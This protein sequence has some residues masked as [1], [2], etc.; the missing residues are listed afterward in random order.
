[1]NES[2]TSAGSSPGATA[3]AD[4]IA[5]EEESLLNCVHCG[6]CLTACPTYARLGDE[7][8]SPRG[9]LYL[10]KAVVEGRMDA[11]SDAF[12]THIDRC[13]GCRAC[14][15][16]CPSGVP[17][18]HLLEYA[19]AEAVAA[20]R[21]GPL[22]RLL[23]G[24]FGSRWTTN[25][26][27][28]GGRIM[29]ATGL[30]KLAARMLPDALGKARFGLAMLASTAPGG[31]EPPPSRGPSDDRL[32]TTQPSGAT[33][34]RAG[35]LLG[36]V[37]AG[38]FAHV[39]AGTERVLRVNGVESVPVPGQGCCGALHAH[40]GDLGSARSLARR[41]I[42][43]F[44]DTGVDM[45][46]VN[47]A[48]CGS[49][50][51][52]YGHLLADD[53]EYAERAARFSRTVRDV[54]EVLADIGPRRGAPL[55]L[56][57]AWDAPCHLLHAQRVVDPPR[58][59]LAAIPELDLVEVENSEECCGGAGVYGLVHEELGGWIGG[60]K[61]AAVI[62]TKAP[63]LATGNPGCMMQIGAGLLVAGSD[64]VV[65]HPVELLDASYRRAG[66]YDAPGRSGGRG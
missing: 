42:D 14:E 60:D 18:G 49:V 22:T 20:R 33:S 17:Y 25:I 21:P 31:W 5:R 34:R 27:M 3:F 50:M 11:G 47:A 9:R 46:I 59:V 37:Q 28:A 40:A 43:V 29:R 6:F 53:P 58:A 66:F 63:V 39:N 24:I 62:D 38:L 65:V 44:E 15:P 55:G 45:V 8:D 41:N 16:V 64:A 12:Q 19:R 57:V 52:D 36:C 2:V 26:A 1:V 48:G 7:N 30:A 4:V 10:M 51:K 35:L 54:S 13:L 32:S 56:R 23:L 61:V